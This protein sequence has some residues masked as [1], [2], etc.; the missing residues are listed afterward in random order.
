MHPLR[1][2]WT[3]A[4]QHWKRLHL[5][6]KDNITEGKR[7]ISARQKQIRIADRSEC[8]WATVEEY[9]ADELASDS[10]DEKRLFRAE[11]RA[12]RKMKSEE[13]KREM[14]KKP[15][16]KREAMKQQPQPNLSESRYGRANAPSMTRPPVAPTVSGPLGPCF[17][18]GKTGHL[19]RFCPENRN[20]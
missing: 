12:K 10:D 5:K 9:L 19:R 20:T 14:A 13:K 11:S 18:C 16:F 2:S 6:A 7:L 8:G 17:Q 3:A 1:R 15:Y 4:L